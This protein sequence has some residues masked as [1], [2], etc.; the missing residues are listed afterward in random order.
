[1]FLVIA[2]FGLSTAGY[3]AGI[4]EF[5]LP[6]NNQLSSEGSVEVDL[7]ASTQNVHTVTDSFYGADTHGFSAL[8]NAGLVAP[9]QLGF[10]KLGGGL[11]SVYSWQLDAYFDQGDNG[12]FYVYSPLERRL[13]LIQEGYHANPMF[14]VNMLGLQPE[15]DEAGKLTLKDTADA[16]YAADAINYINGTKKLGL[17]HI[18][19]GNEPFESEEHYGKAA[20]SADEY[21]ANYIKYAVAVRRAQE[22]VSGNSNDI[23]LWGPEIS[24]GWTGWQ[25]NHPKDCSSESS[26]MKCS[27]GNG[28]FSEFIPY[29]LFRLAQ[30]EKDSV[31]NPRKYKMLDY[32]TMH[33]YPLFRK[34][35]KD[36][37]SIILNNEGTQNVLAMLESVNVWNSETYVNKYDS[38]SLK[39]IAPNIVNKFNSWKSQYYPNAKLALTEFAIDS[40]ANVD[41]HPIVRPLYLADLMARLSTS[42][43]DTFINSFLQSGKKGDGWAMVDGEEKTKLYNVFSLYSNY[44]LGKVLPSNDSFGDKVNVYSVKNNNMT[45]VFLINKD[46]KDHT[47][48]LNFKNAGSVEGVTQ[49][50]LPAWS[51]TVLNVPDDR[52][53]MINVHQYGAKEMNINIDD[54]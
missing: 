8:P 20:P 13:K 42:G 14:Q 3:S 41:Y 12:I 23:K 34:D 9:L 53:Q 15:L 25:T 43:V 29:F 47:T 44:F 26:K 54:N 33:Y 45:N 21:I 39:G 40:V 1:M 19:M 38:A 46:T 35:F 4:S 48:D 2:L 11:H 36:T 30:F 24:T 5:T 18:V 7:G 22:K 52:S 32:L 51:V 50:A 27:Y 10:V 17:K 37:T 31:N 28:K 49:V 16:A 6:F